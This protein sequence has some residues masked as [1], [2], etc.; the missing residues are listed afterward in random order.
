MVRKNVNDPTPKM[1]RLFYGDISTAGNYC[2]LI[3][4]SLVLITLL[5]TSTAYLTFVAELISPAEA[6]WVNLAIFPFVLG[7]IAGIGMPGTLL[8]KI[9]AVSLLPIWHIF[10]FGGDAAK[11]G[12]ENMVALGEGVFI[13]IG[14]G[15]SHFI[16]KLRKKH[17]ML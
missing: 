3:R 16:C 15:L 9:V 8:P 14:L 12:L 4:W 7:C 2:H 5:I 13:W 17:S 1:N 10:F 6:I 11:P